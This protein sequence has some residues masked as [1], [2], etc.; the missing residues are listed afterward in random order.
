[1]TLRR[2]PSLLILAVVLLTTPG[3]ALP[4]GFRLPT[5]WRPRAP[6]PLPVPPRPLPRAARAANPVLPN[7]ASQ[8]SLRQGLMNAT[9]AGIQRVRQGFAGVRAPVVLARGRTFAAPLDLEQWAAEHGYKVVGARS[10]ILPQM[11]VSSREG[12][13]AVRQLFARTAAAYGRRNPS[14][15]IAQWP[16]ART[17]RAT[18]APVAAENHPQP[19][20]GDGSRPGRSTVE[21]LTGGGDGDER[22]TVTRAPATP[23][24][25][26]HTEVS[27]LLFRNDE[28]GETKMVP[29]HVEAGHKDVSVTNHDGTKVTILS[30]DRS[31]RISQIIPVADG[32][33]FVGAVTPRVGAETP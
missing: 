7:T 25:D 1:M 32:H 6:A 29:H 22:P 3:F 24:R 17:E 15:A 9:R 26:P 28:T 16:A 14:G 12:F 23:G 10:Q 4:A 31:G 33:T 30:Q 20:S 27:H 2:L 18:E 13:V 5:P 8:N 11:A 21:R 19:A